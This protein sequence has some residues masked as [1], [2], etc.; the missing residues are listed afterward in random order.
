M[1]LRTLAEQLSSTTKVPA[2]KL[3]R[4]SDEPRDIFDGLELEE[5]QKKVTWKLLHYK[6]HVLTNFFKEFFRMTMIYGLG[7]RDKHPRSMTNVLTGIAMKFKIPIEVFELDLYKKELRDNYKNIQEHLKPAML[8][9]CASIISNVWIPFVLSSKGY[10]SYEVDIIDVKDMDTF[11]ELEQSEREEINRKVMTRIMDDYIN[12][13][14]SLT[15][16]S[17]PYF[18]AKC[19]TRKSEVRLEDIEA[20]KIYNADITII[21]HNLSTTFL[22]FLVGLL[23]SING[24]DTINNSKYAI[25][26]IN[27]LL[28]MIDNVK[29]D[30]DNLDKEFNKQ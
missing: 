29:A 1:K 13:L 21:L 15:L 20:F 17:M 24:S 28:N 7:V 8:S 18:T 19:I 9:L 12:D 14:Y 22:N 5:I 26:S 6:H 23:S 30:I 3:N 4:L 25:H 27:L 2:E 10:M 16:Y 11:M